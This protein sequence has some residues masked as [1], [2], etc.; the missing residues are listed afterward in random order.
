MLLAVR[1]SNLWGKVYLPEARLTEESAALG[2]QQCV[3]LDPRIRRRNPLLTYLLSMAKEGVTT[4]IVFRA[5]G[6]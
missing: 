1:I 3:W 4:C 6:R 2:K 5:R